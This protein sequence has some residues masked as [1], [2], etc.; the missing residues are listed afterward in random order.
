[1]FSILSLCHF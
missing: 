1:M